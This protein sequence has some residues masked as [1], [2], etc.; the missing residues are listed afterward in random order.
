MVGLM[1]LDNDKAQALL[2]EEQA[3]VVEQSGQVHALAGRI[4]KEHEEYHSHNGGREGDDEA[5]AAGDDSTGFRRRAGVEQELMNKLD[6]GLGE[7]SPE[8]MWARLQ[9]VEA[10]VNAGIPIE[11]AKEMVSR[12]AAAATDGASGEAQER[13]DGTSDEDIARIVE[14][15][16]LRADAPS[17]PESCVSVELARTITKTELEKYGADQTGIPDYAMGPAGARVILGHG[18]TSETYEPPMGFMEKVV[19]SRRKDTLK[20]VSQP[21]VAIN[22]E[23]RL[24]MC[25]PMKGTLGRLTV[26]LSEAIKVDA[27]SIEH[28]AR[29]LLLNN[30][31]SALRD[32]TVVGYP[33]NG[34]IADEIGHELV[35]GGEY[36]LEGDVIQFFDVAEQYRQVEYDAVTLQVHSNHGEGLYTCIYRLRVHGTPSKRDIV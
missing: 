5:A 9:E 26:R 16:V 34:G 24:G 21:P 20:A 27:I 8:G 3:A 11:D 31:I 23:S 25:W 4:I 7:A 12:Y 1:T 2:K 14:E 22:P 33:K 6:F 19:S 35:S 13:S 15:I 30:G 32:F 28:G 29:E 17:S 10:N 18:Y 36:R